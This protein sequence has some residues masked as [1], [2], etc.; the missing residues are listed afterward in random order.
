MIT[1]GWMSAKACMMTLGLGVRVR[2][3]T[4]APMHISKRNSNIMPYMCADGSMATIC[5][6]QVICGSATVMAKEMLHHSERYG[7]ITP[8]EKPEVPEV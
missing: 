7:S 1:S 5:D 2:K 6:S 3:C 4:C 8:L